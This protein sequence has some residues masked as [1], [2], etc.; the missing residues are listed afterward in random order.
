MPNHNTVVFKT[1]R[2]TFKSWK[3]LFTEAAEFAT[4]IGKDRLIT[5]SHSADHSEGVITVW[6]WGHP[7]EAER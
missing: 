2:G 1:F 7:S 3:Q 5:I 6:Y 4:G